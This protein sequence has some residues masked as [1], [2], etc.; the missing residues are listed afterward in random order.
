MQRDAAAPRETHG[1]GLGHIRTALR[2]WGMP[3]QAR[4]A[5]AGFAMI[6]VLSLGGC[7]GSPAESPFEFFRQLTGDPL[8]GRATPAGLDATRPNFSA[9]PPR[10]E[11]GPAETRAELSAALAANRAAAA[12]P[13]PVGAPVP[14]RPETEGAAVVPAAPPPPARLRP[15]PA[16]G[17]G[18]AT[19]TFPGGRGGAAPGLPQ[20]GPVPEAP[21]AE[22][23]APAPPN[24][25]SPPPIPRL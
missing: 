23:L 1:S 15:A 19:L 21:P 10:P 12:S 5:Q 25:A 14:P 11:R 9:V 20:L 2:R 4:A 16:V 22:L 13:A 6:G 3:E 24:L 8:Q 7:V 17:T 18:P